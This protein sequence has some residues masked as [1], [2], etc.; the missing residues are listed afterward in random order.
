MP[1]QRKVYNVKV[2]ARNGKTYKME[3]KALSQSDA[4]RI[5]KIRTERYN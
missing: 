4:E 2:K 5:A 1:D 3:V